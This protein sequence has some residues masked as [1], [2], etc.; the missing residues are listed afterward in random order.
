MKI[1][2]DEKK[3]TVALGRYSAQGHTVLARPAGQN[4]PVGLARARRRA[5]AL[6]TVTARGV[7]PALA[8]W[9]TRCNQSGDDS[10]GGGR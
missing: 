10:V 3:K 8:T 1:K 2:K 6:G 5:H 9:R 4:S 7:W